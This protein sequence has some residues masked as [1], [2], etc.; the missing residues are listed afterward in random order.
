MWGKV[1]HGSSSSFCSL[2]GHIQFK[3]IAINEQIINC[4]AVSGNI[5]M[6]CLPFQVAM[7]VFVS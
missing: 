7:F 3:W 2:L 1:E 5:R 4:P 6:I